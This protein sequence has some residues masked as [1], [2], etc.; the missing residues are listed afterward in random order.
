MKH[1]RQSIALTCAVLSALALPA[2]AADN[3]QGGGNSVTTKDVVVEANRAKEAAKWESQQTTIITAEDIEKKQAKSVEDIIFSETG[4]SRT[5]DSMGRVGISIRG[6]EARH[7]L[8]LVDGQ[9]VLGD[10]AKYQGA[11][12]EVMRLG[13]ENVDHIEIIQGAASAKYGSDAIGG[14]VNIITKKAKKDKSVQFNVEGSRTKG[15]G[16]LPYTNVFLRADTGE[17]GKLRLGLSGSKRDIMPV[18]AS[19]AR[20]ESG[21]SFDYKDRNFKPKALR[22]YGEANTIGLVG[23]YDFNDKNKLNFRFDRYTEDLIRDVKHSDSDLEPQQHFKR[24]ADRDSYNLGW[25]G[26]AGASDWNVELNYS[27][28]NEDDVS[29]INY[30]GQSAYEGKNELRYVDDVDHRQWDFKASANTQL[31]DKHLLSYGFGSTY[32]KGSGSR[33]K[34]SPNT[35]TK[36]IDP[37]DYDKNLMVDQ[38][39]R[40]VRKDGD[41]SVRVWSHVHD[42]KFKDSDS[43]VPEWDM[44]YEYYGYDGTNATQMPPVTYENYSK[45]DKY[46]TSGISDWYAPSGVPDDV[47]QNYRKFRDILEAQNP[48]YNGSNIVRDYFQKGESSDK[49]QQSLAPTFNGKKFLEEYRIRDQRITVGNGSIRK[50]NFFIQDTWQ[51]ND[52]TIITPILRLDHSSLFGSN[53]SGSLGMTHNVGGNVHRRFK[54]NVGTSYAEPG[55]GELWYNWEMYASNPVGIGYA[56]LGWY[57][58]GNPN[59]KPEKAV[60]FDISLEGENKNTYAKA[61]LF[62]NRIKDY[63]SV[64]FTGD[65]MDFAPYLGS[66]QKYQRAPDMIYSFKNIG[67]AEITGFEAEVQQKL[68]EH[69]KAKLG[70]TW[71]H[72]INKS[73]PNMPRQLLDKPVHK[74]DIGV[75]FDDK[76]SGWGGSIWG[77]YYINMLD[78]NTLVNGSN[79]WPDILQQKGPEFEK[80]MYQKKTFGLWNFML[81]KKLS[82]D[83][84]VYFGI[85]NIFN[86]RDDD[87]ATQ[88]RVYRFGMNLKFGMDSHTE[89]AV[90]AAKGNTNAETRPEEPKEVALDNF[91]DRPFDVNKKEGVELIGDYRAT[92][93][94]NNGTNRPQSPFR[95]DKTVGTAKENMYDSS[96]HG[97]GQRLRAGIDARIGENTNLRVLGSASG[98][99]GVDTVDSVSK[100]RGLNDQRMENIDLTQRANKWDFSLGRLTEPMGITGYWFGKEFDGGRAVWTGDKTQVRLGYGSFKHSTGITDSAY[101]HSIYTTFY[102]PPTVE[103]FLGLN[104]NDNPYDLEGATK[105]PNQTWEEEYKGKTDNLYFY[106]Q[107]RDIQNNDS[108]STEE[109]RAQQIAVLKR[110]HDIVKAAYGSDMAKQSFVYNIPLSSQVVYKVKNK[111]TGEIKYI[112]TTVYYNSEISD[113]DSD[114]EKAFKTE[115]N[116]KFTIN[117]ADDGALLDGKSYFQEHANDIESAYNTIAERA[118]KENWGYFGDSDSLSYSTYEYTNGGTG[119]QPVSNETGIAGDYAFDGIDR[120]V[121]ENYD[122]QSGGYKITDVDALSDLYK[123]NYEDDNMGDAEYGWAM[124][125]MMF[126][127]LNRMEQVLRSTESEN[128]LPREALGALVGN[129]IKVQGVMLMQDTIPAIDKA[130]FVQVRHQ[131]RPNFGLAAWYFRSISDDS[132]SYQAANG[133]GNDV[134]TFDQLANVIGIGA[135]WQLGDQ[136]TLSFDY[137]QNRTDFGRYMNGHT[138]Y[139]HERGT[140]DFNLFG[141]APGGTPHFWTA[142]LDI[143]K[144]DTDVIGSWNAFADYKYF[145][146]GSFFGGNGTES[147]PD[148]YLDGIRSFTLGA[149]YVPAKDIL[150]EAFYTFDAK[151]ISKRDTLYGPEKFQLG[152]YTKIQMTYRF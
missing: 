2:M 76:T 30:Y 5:V 63:M 67:R 143:G 148:R 25:E 132:H 122:W 111:T 120:I 138:L 149:G 109:K 21:M 112:K 95:A 4:V 88:E 107:L 6:A 97:F 125:Q 151:G 140:A 59:L 18:Y 53:V 55:M 129:L 135:Q 50:H 115:M 49:T 66:S 3:P 147:L 81:Q 84:L 32:E 27:R 137:G 48:G 152:N 43:G 60:N 86:H 45:Y 44:D 34:S 20:S 77:D 31:N 24:E 114:E 16:G 56:K 23:T 15:D 11:A 73:D 74:V 100:S 19:V 116:R 141:R 40:Y 54:A 46:F 29:L 99:D 26:R 41:N 90:D 78:S 7:T 134:S 80:K 61:T 98:V 57:W 144:A 123:S 128:K 130:A 118:A 70:Y 131:L 71:L 126:E 22:Y 9:P 102:R 38:L 37:W 82:E 10:L 87:R 12:D 117:L 42:Y 69:W 150:L 14:V 33:L 92:W 124:P 36:Y 113:Y 101:T 13:T 110:M 79:Y 65:L 91:L 75:T 93:T 133:N 62:H 52:D 28:I 72:A 104:R 64:Y 35:T 127:Y 58:A 39:D 105:E 139:D 83:A 51:V 17:M 96:A 89:T 121:N 68:G 108:L 136:T 106:Q 94:A 146:H 145:Q 119:Y 103:E 47:W 142:R 85:N 1:K 8:I